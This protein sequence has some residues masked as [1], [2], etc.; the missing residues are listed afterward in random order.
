MAWESNGT[1]HFASDSRLTV[2]QNSYADVAIKISTLPITIYDP[3]EGN[4][5]IPRTVAHN[6]V[7]GMCF[8]G[9]AVNSLTIK[10]SVTEVLKGLQHVPGYTDIS[11]NG[12]ASF[13]FKV[14]QMISEEVSKT[15]LGSNGIASILIGGYCT[16][17]NKVR[18]FH[19]STDRCFYH[20]ITEVLTDRSYIFIGSGAQ[21]A[22]ADLPQE[23]TNSD[24]FNILRVCLKI[25][26]LYI[27]F[28]APLGCLRQRLL[29]GLFF[30]G[31]L[32]Q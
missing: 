28:V 20:T 15:A 12:I 22:E 10:E 6:A 9:S 30:N 8:A 27:I 2:A 25:N 11:M 24:Y 19:L 21:Q 13:V 26:H 3:S 32:S 16:V 29:H 7:L 18:V 5:S 4:M 23:P 14:Y 17:Q 31:S 1:V